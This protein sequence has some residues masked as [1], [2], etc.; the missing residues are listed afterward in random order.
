MRVHYD[1]AANPI[2]AFVLMKLKTFKRM[3]SSKEKIEFKLAKLLVLN[4][5]QVKI[6]IIVLIVV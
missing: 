4:L 5:C 6:Y 1:I 2:E 3:K